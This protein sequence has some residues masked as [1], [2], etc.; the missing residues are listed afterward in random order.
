MS[1]LKLGKTPAAPRPKDFKWEDFSAE[2]VLPSRPS[3]FGHANLFSGSDWLMLGNGPDDTVQP[4]FGG[5]GDCVCAG[6]CH[7]VR[8]INKVVGHKDVPFTGKEAIKMYSAVTG[9]VLG[10]DTTDNGTDMG[11]AAEYRR[12]TG[13]EDASGNRHQ[14]AAWVRLAPGN[15]EQLLEATYI[16]L[17]AGIGFLFPASAWPQFH[18]G[19]PWDVMANDGGIDGGHYVPVMGSPAPGKVG[20]VTWARRQ[21]MTQKFYEKYN[22]ETIVYIT[23]EELRQNNT[24][25]HG[26]DMTKLT[27]YLNSL[28]Q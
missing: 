24:D 9:Y 7:E 18:S 6:A 14:V 13:V 4:G 23:N 1:E 17:A 3:R 8:M 16:F 2:I 10:D 20:L 25:V 15:W 28:K 22:D 12:K 21:E 26:F 5:A 27:S 11:Q 19:A